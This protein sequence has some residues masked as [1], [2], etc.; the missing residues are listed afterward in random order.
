MTKVNREIV[1]QSIENACFSESDQ[2]RIL[3]A[4]SEQYLYISRYGV[5]FHLGIF[6]L[7]LGFCET[8]K[9]RCPKHV[10]GDGS[11]TTYIN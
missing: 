1:Q 3:S 9:R 2:W 7:M 5:F 6:L 4:K 11:L 8:I 10:R